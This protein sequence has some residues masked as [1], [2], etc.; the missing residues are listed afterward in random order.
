MGCQPAER[1]PPGRLPDGRTSAAFAHDAPGRLRRQTQRP[2]PH[3]AARVSTCLTSGD[4]RKSGTCSPGYAGSREVLDVAI[5]GALGHP[6]PPGELV[7]GEDRAAAEQ[8]NE[9][10]EAI[11]S[12]R[13]IPEHAADIRVSAARPYH[14]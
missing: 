2:K 7:A 5:D 14:A 3:P 10:E 12:S 13:K 6:E 11:G 4:T 8:R 1:T 9:L